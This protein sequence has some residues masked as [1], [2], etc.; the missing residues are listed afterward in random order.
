MDNI[1]I[2]TEDDEELHEQIVH[3]VL[4]L[5]NEENFF[6]KL[7]KCLFHQRS[8]N[9]L[10][11][12]IEGGYISIDPTKLDG[13]ADW[14]KGLKNVHEVC[15]TLGVFR[16]NWPFIPG[17]SD[18]IWPLTHLIKKDVPFIWTPECTKVIWKLKAAIQTGRVLM[19]PDYSKLFTLEVDASQYA[20]E[21]ILSQENDHG[22]LQPIEHYFKTLI[23]A[24]QNYD[25]Y[26]QE[27]LVLRVVVTRIA[28]S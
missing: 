4:E 13:L 28:K 20:L 27:L 7:S 10:G 8:I 15:A 23:P 17:Y 2:T 6:L 3:E 24:E 22:K 11:I 21:A 19:W 26:N 18:I 16:Y 1:L 5:I 9:Y 14:K 12:Y 25:V